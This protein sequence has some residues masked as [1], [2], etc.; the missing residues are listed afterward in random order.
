MLKRLLTIGLA[1]L[2]LAGCAKPEGP[3]Q[4]PEPQVP[5]PIYPAD[6][7]V[8]QVTY[9]G[10]FI[11]VDRVSQLVP[12]VTIWGDGR[13]VFVDRNDS[14]QEGRIERQ[15]L[16]RLMAEATIL[17]DLQ[18]QYAAAHHT[19]DATATFTTLTER[20]RKTVSVYALNPKAPPLS[21]EDHPEIFAKLR[22]FWAK[23]IAALPSESIAF[24]PTEVYVS[25]FYSEEQATAEWPASLQG[26]LTG[27]QASEAIALGGL[28]RAKSFL[29]DGKVQRVLLIP[30]LPTPY[31]WDEK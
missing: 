21:G 20:G 11:M 2:L 10:G 30:L 14:L 15:V 9:G 19:D 29:V 31:N 7:P 25:T 16:D 26:S 27:A 24:M 12:A 8:L 4:L 22:T 5:T 1:L 28:G 23:V 13:V 6:K 17:Y 18:D 3:P